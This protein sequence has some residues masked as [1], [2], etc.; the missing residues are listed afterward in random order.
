MGRRGE[1]G[2]WRGAGAI[3]PGCRRPRPS[4]NAWRPSGPTGGRL[5]VGLRHDP[6][7]PAAAGPPGPSRTDPSVVLPVASRLRRQS[8]L[9]RDGASPL[10]LEQDSTSRGVR[11]AAACR[12]GGESQPACRAI[13]VLGVSIWASIRR[14]APGT[15]PIACSPRTSRSRRSRWRRTARHADCSDRSACRAQNFCNLPRIPLCSGGHASCTGPTLGKRT[16]GGSHSGKHAWSLS[17]LARTGRLV[18]RLPPVL[19]PR[20]RCCPRRRGRRVRRSSESRTLCFSPEVSSVR[21]FPSHLVL[22]FTPR[23]DASQDRAGEQ[24]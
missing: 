11:T 16:T 5:P 18:P 23:A 15:R 19:M 24:G 9:P 1:T 14:G 6:S 2:C 10:C 13:S 20:F 7:C 17:I 22:A 12:H 8:N 21:R 3:G 4:R